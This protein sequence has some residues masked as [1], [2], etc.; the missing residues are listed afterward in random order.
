MPWHWPCI[1]APSCARALGAGRSTAPPWVPCSGGRQSSSCPRLL[2]FGTGAFCAYA[3]PPP[4]RVARRPRSWRALKSATQLAGLEV[5]HA[6]CRRALKS[7]TQLAGLEVGHATRGPPLSSASLSGLGILDVGRAVGPN[8]PS[9]APPRSRSPPCCCDR[10]ASSTP[11]CGGAACCDRSASS[12]SA[13]ERLAET[14]L[15]PELPRACSS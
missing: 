12:T 7:A 10:S 6:R 13:A 15:E 1:H 4:E 8:D 11:K 9:G 2:D 14:S 3:R 5:G